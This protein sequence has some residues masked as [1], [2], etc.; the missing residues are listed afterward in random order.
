MPRDQTG[1]TFY[2]VDLVYLRLMRYQERG[3]APYEMELKI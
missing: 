2:W 3:S 1:R